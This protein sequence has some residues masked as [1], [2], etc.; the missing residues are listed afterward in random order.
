MS[1]G[2][3][4]LAI[5]GLAALTVIT[6]GFFFL[7]QRELPVPAALTQA[8][9][10]APLAALAAVIAPEVLMTQGQLIDTWTDA[11][12]PAVAAGLAYYF[13]RRGIVGT[14][15]CGMAVLLILRL[16]WGW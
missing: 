12:L 6:R 14:I 16:G 13:C 4:L 11:R 5:L 9:R 3:G 2:W 8:L 1:L 15:V 7:T 10:Y